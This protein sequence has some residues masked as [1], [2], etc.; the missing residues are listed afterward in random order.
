M[1][2]KERYD[3][4]FLKT[5]DR[6]ISLTLYKAK[7]N[8]VVSL[9][10]SLHM[11]PSIPDQS[12]EKKKPNVI[13]DYN[14]MKCGVDCFDAMARMFSTRSGSR[15]WP[16]YILYNV[17]DICAINSWVLYT[18]VTGSTIS[19]RQFMLQLIE[20]LVSLP[21]TSPVSR[22][23]L[24][25]DL[26][27]AVTPSKRRHCFSSNCANKTSSVCYQ[28]QKPCCGTHTTKKTTMFLCCACGCVR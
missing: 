23:P 19:R 14:Q 2:N 5:Q 25:P 24:P 1:K 18:K 17:L 26:S 7:R 3:S 6:S 11:H 22:P 27:E 16:L 8:K 12:S 15:R 10:S 28:C 13:L 9:I 21:S 20:E 4:C